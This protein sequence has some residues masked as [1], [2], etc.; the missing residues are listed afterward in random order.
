MRNDPGES[1]TT[2]DGDPLA[3]APATLLFENNPN[4]MWVFE[5]ATLAFVAVNDAAVARYGYSR[6]EFLSMTL[7]DIRPRED[8]GPLETWLHQA[9]PCG[10]TSAGVWRHRRK[11]GTVFPVEILNHGLELGDRRCELVL[12]LDVSERQ[13]AREERER[14]LRE[15]AASDRLATLGALAGGLA[16]ELNNPLS[17]VLSNLSYVERELAAL[18]TGGPP[19]FEQVRALAEAV[20]DAL[21]GARRVHRVV[22]ELRQLSQPADERLAA[23]EL[24]G[25]VEGALALAGNEIRHR[26]RLELDLDE[27]PVVRGDPAR[28]GQV[29]LHLLLN[30]A[31]AIRPGER[32]RHLIQ[33]A[34]RAEGDQAVLEVTDTGPAVPER[35]LPRVFEPFTVTRADGAGAGLG[36]SICRTLVCGMGGE[37]TADSGRGRNVFQARL[38]LARPA[39][40]RDAPPG[41]APARLPRV[42]LLDDEEGIG[43]AVRRALHGFAEVVCETAG[44]QALQRFAAGERFDLVLC[45]VMMPQMTGTQF[46]AALAQLDPAAARDLV[47]VSGGAFAGAEREALALLPNERL[48]KPLDLARL[49]SLL[50]ARAPH[51]PPAGQ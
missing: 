34:A 15:L 39:A 14:M 8:V 36:L 46:H 21:E 26:A 1:S 27:A 45:D 44:R 51:F 32:E 22:R 49:R 31:L 41:A 29:A 47:F 23:V 33:V 28:L 7:R 13:R 12:A 25:V 38:P 24:H 3:G 9:Q 4:P 42:L 50:A 17:Y 18:A 43:R 37:L 40:P 20:A 16:H 19:G 48:E 6:A 30:A 10:S 2:L 5:R 11:D 35:A